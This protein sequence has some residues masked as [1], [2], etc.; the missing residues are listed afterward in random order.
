MFRHLRSKLFLSGAPAALALSFHSASTSLFPVIDVGNDNVVGNIESSISSCEGVTEGDVTSAST[1]PTTTSTSTAS[2]VSSSNSTTSTTSNSTRQKFSGA[3]CNNCESDSIDWSHLTYSFPSL[4]SDATH[5]TNSTVGAT[6][7][8]RAKQYA[9]FMRQSKCGNYYRQ[10]E[11]MSTDDHLKK[12]QECLKRNEDYYDT[13]HEEEI[14]D[15][16]PLPPGPEILPSEDWSHLPPDSPTGCGMCIFMRGSPCGNHFR[17]WDACVQ[18]NSENDENGEPMYLK[19]CREESVGMFECNNRESFKQWMEIDKEMN[20][21]TKSRLESTPSRFFSRTD[22]IKISTLNLPI[23]PSPSLI[24]FAV[25]DFGDEIRV[26][27]RDI[28]S[29]L[30]YDQGEYGEWRKTRNVQADVIVYAYVLEKNT[31]EILGASNVGNSITD[32]RDV[33]CKRNNGIMRARVPER[34]EEVEVY[35]V[36]REKIYMTTKTIVPWD[37]EEKE[38]KEEEERSEETQAPT[39]SALDADADKKDEV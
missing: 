6:V 12:L 28:L 22:L 34:G 38:E 18:K 17:G 10:W 35:L 14:R 25:I 20:A 27:L 29:S 7:S 30:G 1:T 13:V 37:S 15:A 23:Q 3:Y 4:Q 5:A 9:T 31:G 24:P 8:S 36:G 26:N 2:T 39:A 16:L 32:V 33:A 11:Q 21:S 19:M